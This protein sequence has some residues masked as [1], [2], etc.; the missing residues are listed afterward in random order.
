M[1]NFRF[2]PTGPIF[3]TFLVA[4]ASPLRGQVPGELGA[5]DLTGIRAAHLAARWSDGLTGG[6][7][8][9]LDPSF[10][11]QA[12]RFPREASAAA[13]A[14]RE[15]AYLKPR[16]TG[17]GDFFATVAVSGDTVVVGAPFE[18]SNSLLINGNS[19]SNSAKN[20]GAAYVFVKNSGQW[21]QQAYLKANDG[22]AGDQFGFS[23]A[24]SG[25]TVVVGAYAAGDPVVATTTT[26]ATKT[27]FVGAAYVFLRT[28]TTWT[29]QQI[30]TP[31][32]KSVVGDAFGYSVA[33]AGDTAV[34]GAIGESTTKASAPDA[35]NA[36]PVIPAGA[37][38]VF[39]RSGTT[40]TQQGYLK[41]SKPEANDLFGIAVAVSGDTVV[42]GAP[43]ESGNGKGADGGQS[44]NLAKSS[45]AAYVFTR[46]AAAWKPQAYLKAGN[47]GAGDQFGRAVGISGER[48]IVGAPG[49]ASSAS[50]VDGNPK[51]N[52]AAKAGAAYVFG[53]IKS[54][55]WRQQAY[56]KAG[57][58]SAGDSFGFAVAISGGTAV[59]GAMN[60]RA[61]GKKNAGA[62][63]VYTRSQSG[64]SWQSV[65][66]AHNRGAGDKLG[67]SVAVYG[68]TVV[69]GALSEAGDTKIVN[70]PSSNRAKNAGAAYV[71]E[72]IGTAGP[73]IAVEQPAG[74]ALASGEAVVSFGT[75][76]ATI[77]VSKTFSIVNTGT[78]S[79]TGVAVSV[80]GANPAD[81]TVDTTKMATTVL[82]GK[83]TTF[84]VT[85]SSAISTPRTATVVIR[86]N[87][88][89][90]SEF[91][92]ALQGNGIGTPVIGL[93]LL[94]GADLTDD[95]VAIGFGK[96]RLGTN[97]MTKEFS[98]RNAGNG[99]LKNLAISASGLNKKDFSVSSLGVTELA[100]DEAATFR[101]TFTPSALY[102]R[103][104]K[105][106]VASN[107]TKS[108]P[109]GINVSGVSTAK[110][111]QAKTVAP[112]LAEIVLGGPSSSVS[113]HPARSVTVIH[114]E[115][116][117][118]LSVTKPT[119]GSPVG[120]IQVSP[121]LL[122]WYSGSQH[123][124]VVTDDAITLKVRDNTPIT[125]ETKRYIRVK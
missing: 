125:P 113:A 25:E 8:V 62:A 90:E 86:S 76:T 92:I 106:T 32:V 9:E 6:D 18:D 26:P 102:K 65:L 37:A 97:G 11:S 3:V 121:N 83:S 120:V 21:V 12:L 77:P 82:K 33:V 59:V 52:S 1:M 4:A 104:A 30:L 35:T 34:I 54:K 81:F 78:T 119:D 47:T 111:S 23:V 50:R 85:F 122:D 63:H 87:G 96:A 7:P 88:Q 2:R 118:A 56:L 27:Q 29:Q 68:K 51:N 112:G 66:Q 105:I 14:I 48:I 38:F 46:T 61:G 45:G 15:N 41:A 74:T 49:E 60:E 116:F 53:R 91:S 44:N 16:N 108:G 117:L 80:V 55:T 22:V 10:S 94:D 17:A 107:D 115:K 57:K 109:F 39:F 100:P 73:A 67:F 20:S 79:L 5:D 95:G 40:W 103:I 13:A 70:G 101:V 69:C 42:V 28:G 98:V 89:N 72:G 71:F 75:T 43:N 110:S 123:T 24:I 124:T 93:S 31:T 64:W 36:A 58:S 19:G 99:I 84:V 114:G